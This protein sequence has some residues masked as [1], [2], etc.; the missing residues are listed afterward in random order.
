[1]VNSWVTSPPIFP[2][3]WRKTAISSP[4]I[5]ISLSN[6]KT[7]SSSG[8]LG[9]PNDAVNSETSIVSIICFKLRPR[10]TSFDSTEGSCR[11]L[12]ITE[13]CSIS[14][15]LEAASRSN[16]FLLDTK[17]GSS[18]ISVDVKVVPESKLIDTTA[19]MVI[20]LDSPANNNTL[21][22]FNLSFI[23]QTLLKILSL[24]MCQQTKNLLFMPDICIN[25]TTN[26]SY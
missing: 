8:I 5:R 22:R 12:F 13:T 24:T 4:W 17:A 1:M 20:A 6:N 3:S 16:S 15:V 25:R 2:I 7:V 19:A 21:L 11:D 10:K 9:K 23:L 18:S 14:E 26:T